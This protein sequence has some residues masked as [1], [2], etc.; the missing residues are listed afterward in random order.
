MPESNQVGREGL[1]AAIEQAS[2]GVVITDIAGKIQYVNPAFT[3]MTG[4]TAEEVAGQNPRI[5]KSGREPAGSYQDLWNTVLAGRIWHGELVNRR[6]DGTFYDEEMRITPVR[7]AS[8][9]IV[10]FIATKHDVTEAR[11]AGDAR[12]F[13]AAIVESSEDAIVA[14]TTA[15]IILTWN[16]G[17][18]ALFG[19]SAG[20]AVGKHASVLVPAERQHL[21]AQLSERVLQGVAVPQYEGLCLHRDGRSFPVSVTVCPIRNAA[22]EVAAVSTIMRDISTRREA[23]QAQALLASIVESS[24]NAIIAVGLDGSIVTWNRAAETLFGY[25]NE[26]IIGKD[27]A[28]LAPPDLAGD[29]RQSLETIR[30]GCRIKPFET[31]RQRKD[32]ARIDVSLSVSPIRN[33]AGE[34]VGLSAIIH[35]IGKRLST[36][37]KLQ[38]SEE[39]FREVFEQSPIGMCVSGLDGR[40]IQVN[41]AFCRMLGYTEQGLLATTWVEL[42]HPDDLESSLQG[43]ERLRNEPGEFMESEKRYIHRGGKVV[44]ARRRMA[45]IR[46][47]G[48]NPQYFLVHAEDITERKRTEEA[49]RESEERFRIMAD[50]CPLGIWVTD[51]QGVTRFINRAYREFCGITSE[52]VERDEGLL[53]LRPADAAKYAGVLQ[54]A[55]RDRAPFKAE[56][57]FLRADGEWRWVELYATPRLSTGGEYLGHV[58]TSKD[59]TERK[60][61]EDALRESEARFRNMADGCPAVMWVTDA[62]GQSQFINRAYRRLCGT[63]YEELEGSKWQLLFHPDD[64]R[65]YVGAFQHAVRE[66]TPFQAE[67]RVRCADGEWGWFASYAEPRF[68]PGGEFLGHV[69]LS[70]DITERKQAEQERQFRHSLIRAINEVSPDGILVVNA[71]GIV[72]SHNQRFM[73]V[74]RIPPTDLPGNQAIGGPDQPLLSACTA[75]VKDPEGFVK[76]ARALYG[77]PDANDHCEIELEDGRTLERYSTSIRLEGSRYLGRVW[78]FRDITERKQAEQALRTSE[79]KFRQ[80]AENVREVF[81]MASPVTDEMLYVS[82]A[83]EQVWGKTCNSLYR[84]P[85]SWLEAIHPDDL[86]RARALSARQIQGEPV[87]KEYRIRTPD[88]REKWIRDRAFPVRGQDGRVIRVVGIAE[89]I[90]EQ[91][92]YEEEL[93]QAREDAEAAN[94]AKSCFLANMSHEIRTPMNGVIGMLQLLEGTDLTPQQQRFASVAQTSGRAL[95]T[96]IDDILD[97]SKIEA[98]KVVLEKLSFELRDTIEESV[99]PIEAEAK[100]KGLSIRTRVAADIPLLVEG[101]PHRLRQILSNLCANAVKF[102]ERGG[103]VVDASLA[104]GANGKA[105]VRFTVTDTGIGIRPDKAAGLFAPFTQADASTTRRYGGTGLGLAISKQLA[106]M[107]GGTIGVDSREGRGSA[108]WFTAVFDLASPAPPQPA[109]PGR[110]GHSGMAP[111]GRAARILV[112]ED[113][114]TNREVALAQLQKLGHQASAVAN[115][116]EAVEAVERGGFDLVLMDCQMPVMDGFEAARRIRGSTRADIAGIPVVA[117]TAAAMRDD[118]DRCLREMND[119]ISKPVELEQLAGALAKWLPATGDGPPTPPRR[120]G[121]PADR[122]GWIETDRKRTN[123]D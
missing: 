54:R 3:E 103:I 59:I 108:F 93:I 111:K 48:G 90:T 27:V 34:V 45:L 42:T 123:D 97:L 17:A 13:L 79:E 46:D 35:D 107:M 100:A 15:G 81:W 66:H 87:E 53:R 122:A 26:E 31:V 56:V 41:A 33:P 119:Y 117:I 118:R 112:A 49:L 60:H 109:D 55:V 114:A 32:G 99:Q 23:E 30:K 96:L 36:E 78:F 40:F 50:S 37:R 83:Y 75:R 51:A 84:S 77:D 21:L 8:G 72:V 69:G 52:R 22:G 20:E 25:S 98:R 24:D 86:Q 39:L 68:S 16:R 120:G 7:D 18:E 110:E 5:L 91:K 65:E 44:W 62:E 11:A 88:G 67:A 12:R 6:K 43:M 116:A 2:D 47:D 105:T 58:G 102:T 38:K 76:R 94:R 70:F 89:D 92:R 1:L 106:E 61:A 4:Y 115:G 71:E 113:N 104:S 80:L 95:M 74:W 57:R 85:K 64:A 10:S 28:I 73:E 82:P 63:G 101:D 14:F 29:V 9:A 121:V 19:Y